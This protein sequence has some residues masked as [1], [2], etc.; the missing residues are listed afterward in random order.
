MFVL[1]LSGIQNINLMIMD[2]KTKSS[3]QF[4]VISDQGQLTV[5]GFSI[6]MPPRF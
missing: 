6:R 4:K 1:K 3:V 2:L 5:K